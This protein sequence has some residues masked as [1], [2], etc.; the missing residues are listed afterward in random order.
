L[1]HL[2]FYPYIS[3]LFVFCLKVCFFP[4]SNRIK[5][6]RGRERDKREREET[7]RERESIQKESEAL[8]LL[9]LLIGL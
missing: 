9:S 5:R 6:G 1:V 3:L 2:P 4:L 8:S 7:E